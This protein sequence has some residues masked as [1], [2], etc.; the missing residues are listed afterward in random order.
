MSGMKR[1]LSNKANLIFIVLIAIVFIANQSYITAFFR[2]S[3]VHVWRQC[4]GASYALNYYQNGAT[5]LKPQVMH[6]LAKDGIAV[7]ELPIV[8]KL[9]AWC[10]SIFGFRDYFIRWIH[11]AIYLL[12]LFYLLRLTKEFT[13]NI[14]LQLIP[15]SFLLTA[16]FIYYYALNFLP[17]VAALSLSLVGLFYFYKYQNKA[18][19][20]WLLKA[21]FWFT[22]AGLLK[23]S[24]MILFVGCMLYLIYQ[25]LRLRLSS[26]VNN[27]NN[28]DNK[29]I[30]LFLKTSIV[31]LGGVGIIFCWVI[32]CQHIAVTSGYNGNLLGI[33]P[34]WDNL[35]ADNSYIWLRIKTEWAQVFFNKF[36]LIIL[37]LGL[38][39]NLIF[40]RQVH[41]FL[42][43]LLITTFLGVSCYCALW[44][45]AFMHHDYYFINLYILPIV[46]LLAFIS[47]VEKKGWM[48]MKIN[49]LIYPLLLLGTI[50]AIM[51]SSKIQQERY[52]NAKHQVVNP[53]WYSIEP[54]L[55]S[56]GI[57]RTDFVYSIP[58]PSTNISLYLMN[59]IGFTF[60]Y[61]ANDFE[62]YITDQ[63]VKY[64]LV[65]DSLITMSKNVQPYCSLDKKVGF[66]KGI[67]I[68]K[69]T[70]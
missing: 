57:K 60:C 61:T 56:I 33:L 27:T 31:L 35:P 5:F 19:L 17:D 37:A 22:L 7:S 46:I 70:H 16:P 64:L 15:I 62:K 36:Q 10:Y 53:A 59:N 6:R 23:V 20:Q 63:R 48:E 43:F 24:S 38:V 66:Y 54:Y 51:Y 50:Y 67:Q 18:L 29:N 52:F 42:Q 68:Y 40:W 1:F 4:D 30:S 14:I 58:D 34:Y 8:Y 13:R 3:S 65:A 21:V 25:F 55:R 28:L 9:A 47:L 69:V 41:S 45:Q 12:G 39:I 11:F 49:F 44:Y 26:K 32:Y 2:P